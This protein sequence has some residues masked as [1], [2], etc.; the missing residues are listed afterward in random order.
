MTKHRTFQVLAEKLDDGAW[1]CNQCGSEEYSGSVPEE[2]FEDDRMSCTA[3]GG[4][5]FHWVK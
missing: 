1:V 2:D 4:T 3:C 5:E